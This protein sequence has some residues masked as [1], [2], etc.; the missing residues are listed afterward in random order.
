MQHKLTGII[1]KTNKTKVRVAAPSLL[2][3]QDVHEDCAGHL[4]QD[5]YV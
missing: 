2:D 3:F 1:L 5:L 4:L